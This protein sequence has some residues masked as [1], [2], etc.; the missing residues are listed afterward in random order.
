MSRR[1]VIGDKPKDMQSSAKRLFAY[2]GKNLKLMLIVFAFTVIVTLCSLYGSYAISPI[3]ERVEA[4][5]NQLMS[6]DEAFTQITNLLLVLLIIYV[7]EVIL[8]Y[9]SQ[10]IM[11]VVSQRTVHMIRRDLFKKVMR[12]PVAYH[13]RFTHGEL[14]SRFTNDIDLVSEALNMSA[15]SIVT[16]VLSLIGTVIVMFVLSPVLAIITVVILPLLSLMSSQIVKYSKRYSKRQ[17]VSLGALNGFIEESI[18]GQAV[19]QLF[20]HEQASMDTFKAL[21]KTFKGNAQRAQIA[22]GIMFPLMQNLNNFTYAIMGGVGG[23]LVLNGMMSI[24]QLSAFV[25]LSRTLSRPINEIAMQYTTLQSAVASAERLFEVLDWPDEAPINQGEVLPNIVGDVKFESVVFGYN[26]ERP[27]L[28]SV[29]FYAKPGQKIAFVG[30]TGAG[31]TTITNLISRFYDIQ[32][33][34]ILIDDVDL[35]DLNRFELRRHIA[36]VLQDTHLFTGTVMDNIRYGN[37]DASDEDCIEAAKLANAHRF[38]EQ[39]EFGYQTIISGDGGELSQGQCQLLN[40]A[41]AAVAN[42]KILILDEATSS[43]DT[44]TERLIEKGMDRLMQGRTTFVIAHRLSTVRNADAILV[45]E[46]GQIIERGDHDTLVELKGRYASL[47]S[48]QSQLD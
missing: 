4:V 13:D 47:Y 7:V 6:V 45:I 46:Q 5:I 28:K 8:T 18:E 39:L 25:S 37:L 16:N 10:R 24:A 33:G 22:S 34:R 38:I 40:I 20:N 15:V 26:P 19:L 32:S 9:I 12:I 36:M 35:V 3:V 1:M 11:I 27:V 44:R 31:K 42:P 30:S 21:N 29:S 41:R 14:M 23:Y 17:Q 2:L 43:I 48:G